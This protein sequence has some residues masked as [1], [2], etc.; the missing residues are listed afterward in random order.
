MTNQAPRKEANL[1]NNQH[2]EASRALQIN[3]YIR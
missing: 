3:R 1:P 2:A